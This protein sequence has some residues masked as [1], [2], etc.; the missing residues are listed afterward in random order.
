MAIGNLLGSDLFNLLGVLGL[1]GI[2]NPTNIQSDI[3][4]SIVVLIIMVSMVLL[5]MRTGWQITRLQGTI[6]VTL[7]LIRWY[8][9][10]AGR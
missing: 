8:L 1:A 2:I 3:H 9:D 10:F 4:S 6:L 7:N 5:M